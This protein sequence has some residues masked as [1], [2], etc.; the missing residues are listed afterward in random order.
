[1]V[2]GQKAKSKS[3]HS[4]THFF[5]RNEPKDGNLKKIHSFNCKMATTNL[6][7]QLL[8]EGD[9]LKNDPSGVYLSSTNNQQFS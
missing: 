4:E 8:I 7:H 2:K 9:L 5:I 6:P 1:M 3:N